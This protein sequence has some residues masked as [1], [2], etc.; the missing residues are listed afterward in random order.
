MAS[1]KTLVETW[2]PRIE[3]AK[4]LHKK[5]T[6]EQRVN[7]CYNYWK[8]DQLEQE[9]DQF[10]NRRAQIN[11]IHPE[12]R[13][14][15]PSL[16]YYR[17][18]I[19]LTAAPENANDPGSQ[20]EEDTQLLQDTVNHLVRDPQTNFRESTFIGLKEAHWA[21][22]FAEVGYSAEFSDA[23]N[24]DRPALKETKDTK[25]FR[26]KGEEGGDEAGG[27][28]AMLGGLPPEPGVIPEMGTIAP[29]MGMEPP[30]DLAALSAPPAPEMPPM[31]PG[32]DELGLSVDGGSS[33]EAIQAEVERLK[34]QMKQERFY[35]KHIPAKQ[36]LVS[37]SD[38]PILPDNDWVGYWEDVPLEDV[39]RSPAYKTRGLKANTG[40]DDF[41]NSSKTQ[42]EYDEAAGNTDKVRLFKI[43]DL[44]TREK[45][46]LAQGHDKELMRVPFKRLPLKVLR[47]DIDPYHFYPRPLILSK[48]GPQDE[49]NDSREY[50]RKIR[51]GTVPR[52]TYDEDGIDAAQ[53]QKLE[54]GEMGIYVPRKAGT[55]NVIEP[56]NQP[57]FSENAI[58]TLTLSDKEFADVGGVGGDAKVASTKTATQAKIAETKSQVQDSFDRLVVSEWLGDIASE[59][60]AL[61]I[62]NM[63]IDK[64]V[65]IN[66]SPDGQ[67]APQ[68]GA[69]VA[70]RF[71]RINADIL[72]DAAKGISYEVQIDL[73]SLSP[74]AEEEKFQKWMQGLSLFGNPVMARMFSVAPPLLKR[75]LD[76]LGV[77]SG[78]DQALITGAMQ[79][80]VQME[81]QLAEQGQNAAPGVSP[82]AGAKGPGAPAP[83]AGPRPPGPQP[84]QPKP[85]PT[86]P[87][88]APPKV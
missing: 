9:M 1:G 77:K 20:I 56:I 3:L 39:K 55:M 69:D 8:G 23:P 15:I 48:L 18:F 32:M 43:W 26:P 30:P 88:A 21:F 86:G 60:L 58:Q 80:I 50:L 27:L 17:P 42:K 44:R 70:Q 85:G 79:Q 22:G 6:E 31:E 52:Y 73:E 36:F 11:K 14:N 84:G 59:L 33:L 46:V 78:A 67:F 40:S 72:G 25:V 53:L 49:Y 61:A 45:I 68:L 5:W 82:Q 37:C 71:Q 65:A 74:V 24:A 34:G 51:K 57:S 10:G 19:R 16:Y 75:T 38:K 35:V 4:D 87:G 83:G 66:V 29:E 12:V 7:S 41:D 2:K 64:W 81:Q 63:S 13:N 47:F 54:S 62:D 28:A 76:L